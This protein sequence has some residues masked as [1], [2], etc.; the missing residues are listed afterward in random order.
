[1]LHKLCDEIGFMFLVSTYYNK[2]ALAILF[3]YALKRRL[4]ETCMSIVI[5]LHE[6]DKERITISQS[7]FFLIL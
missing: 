7:T 5:S 4:L 3:A 2:R 1:M 6:I